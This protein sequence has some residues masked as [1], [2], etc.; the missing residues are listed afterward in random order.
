MGHATPEAAALAGDGVTAATT[1]L[2]SGS[3]GKV[4]G[5]VL[6][7]PAWGWREFVWCTRINGEWGEGSSSS[8]HTLW[9][10]LEGDEDNAGYLA[11]WGDLADEDTGALSFEVT[12]LGRES[13]ATVRNGHWL[14]IVDQVREDQI[15]EPATLV[16]VF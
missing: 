14:W 8:G 13:M 3:C 4:A 7:D 6:Q 2:V 10:H 5:V 11:S 9:T 12:F 1:V 15:D 16:A